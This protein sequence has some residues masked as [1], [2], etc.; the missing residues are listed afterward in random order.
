[1]VMAVHTAQDIASEAE[2]AIERIANISVL[3]TPRLKQKTELQAIY[4]KLECM[5]AKARLIEQVIDDEYVPVTNEF[6]ED[7]DT[8]LAKISA[9]I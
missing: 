9:L 6:I 2:E 8:I 3:T 1:V 7:I 4:G 5:Q